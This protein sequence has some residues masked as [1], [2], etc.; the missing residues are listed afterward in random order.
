MNSQVEVGTFPPQVKRLMLIAAPALALLVYFLLPSTYTDISGNEV[1]FSHA[2]RACLSV[3]LWMALWWFT[4]AV[5]IAVT[6]MLPIVFFPLLKITSPMQAMSPYAS[7]TIFLFMGG[8]IL[9]IGVQRWGLDRR[10]ALTV[11]R[12]IG[13][14]A[15][16]IVFGLMIATAVMSMWVSNT[17]TAAMM[18]PIAVAILHL[19]RQNI[20]GDMQKAERNFGLCVLLA[21]AYSASI[22]GMG[23]IIGSPPNGI[24]VRFMEQTYGMEVGLL[25]WMSVGVPVM[26]PLLLTAWFVLC[27]V[28]FRNSIGEV[29]GGAAWVKE[30]LGRLGPMNK[31]EKIVACVFAAAV[32]LWSSGGFL[33]GLEIAGEQPFRMMSDAIIAMACALLLFCIPVNKEENT[34][35]L[36]WKDC[37]DLSWDVLLLFGGGLSMASALQTTGCGALIGA[38]AAGLAGTPEWLVTIGVSTIV[39]SVSNF[40][41]NTALAATMM[42]LI[43]NIAPVLGIMPESI[44]LVTALSASAAFMLPV[45]TPPNAIIFATGRISIMDMVKTGAVLTVCSVII[46]SLVTILM[47]GAVSHF[48]VH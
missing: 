11:L 47:H 12:V 38:Q 37:S 21:I 26:V 4:E 14:K 2:G 24:Y 3:V 17:A 48:F 5:P 34:F 25:H 32:I 7:N 42:P 8:F 16:A 23:T 36:S 35:V 19:V 15:N 27:K 9:A 43:S 45:G 46:I 1:A 44:L 31:G 18:V 10:I 6:A 41:S 39:S 20:G 28:L 29:K 22:G 30:E 40:T 13:T 33:R